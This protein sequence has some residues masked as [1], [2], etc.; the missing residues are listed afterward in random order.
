MSVPVQPNRP[1]M[2]TLATY[3]NEPG[4][5]GCPPTMADAG[6]AMAS[7]HA[8][9]ASSSLNG[10]RMEA[11]TPGA[12]ETCG[13][14]YRWGPADVPRGILQR[15]QSAESRVPEPMAV[16]DPPAFYDK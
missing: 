15:Y 14:V 9:A 11:G 1:S 7:V 3:G 6:E 10:R 2:F 4:A 12:P 16:T 5:A 8:A 13:N